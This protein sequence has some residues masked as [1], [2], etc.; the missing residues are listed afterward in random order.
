MCE[1]N[2]LLSI[3]ENGKLQEINDLK[4]ITILSPS[5]KLAEKVIKVSV[6][7]VIIKGKGRKVFT[8]GKKYKW[9]VN[10]TGSRFVLEFFGQIDQI[11]N[12]LVISVLDKKT[13]QPI[14]GL[15]V[16]ISPNN[17]EFLV[18]FEK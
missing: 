5:K 12:E 4:S 14:N 7:P 11:E 18:N 13:H 10:A 3:S 17:N 15:K 1:T 6:S 2:K 8:I 16:L 9:Q